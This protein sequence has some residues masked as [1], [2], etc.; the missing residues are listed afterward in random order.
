MIEPRNDLPEEG[1]NR[2]LPSTEDI[3][4]RFG[5]L[6]RERWEKSID[7]QRRGLLRHFETH[8]DEYAGAVERKARKNLVNLLSLHQLYLMAPDAE[9]AL[10]DMR[11]RYETNESDEENAA[12][13]AVYRHV[14]DFLLREKLVEFTDV[15]KSI[16]MDPRCASFNDNRVSYE[17]QRFVD[18]LTHKKLIVPDRGQHADSPETNA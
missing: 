7:G 5:P 8:P 2:P 12:I 18:T 16:V 3:G 9:Q 15:R 13:G 4:R 14:I 1:D 6:A 10:L 11:A 17:Y